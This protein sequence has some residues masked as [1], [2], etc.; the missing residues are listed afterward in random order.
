MQPDEQ[1]VATPAPARRIG[2]RRLLLAGLLLVLLAAGVPL[3]W[4]WYVSSEAYHMRLLNEA[5]EHWQAQAI[6]SYRLDVEVQD[7]ITRGGRPVFQRLSINSYFHYIENY[8]QRYS[9]ACSPGVG[10]RRAI[11]RRAYVQYDDE[12]GYPRRVT[13][14]ESRHPDWFNL[15]YWQWFVATG[16]WE[17]CENILCT[18]AEETLIT[19]E[20]VP[21]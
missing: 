7:N 17:H 12:L 19:I 1:Q 3:G 6:G 11:S 21:D 10:C 20:L 5:R 9:F 15:A 14:S 18:S 16:Q 2:W 4:R 13:L 8:W